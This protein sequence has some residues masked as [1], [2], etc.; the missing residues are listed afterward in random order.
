[1]RGFTL[2]EIL[3]VLFI[4]GITLSFATLSIGGDGG[5]ERLQREANR[6]QALM[7]IAK[8]DA[9]LFG[10]EIGLDLTRDGYRF[11]RLDVDGWRVIKRTDTPLRPRKLPED[12]TLRLL[13]R[14]DEDQAVRPLAPMGRQDDEGEG[15]DEN[16]DDQQRN[17]GPRPEVLFL[18]SG[19]T[20]PFEL[21]LFA[22]DVA[23]RYLFKG[24]RSGK[25]RMRRERPAGA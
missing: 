25:I 6:L 14:E 2:V 16:S 1:M 23:V 24:E 11:L 5:A 12:M 7:D 9:V 18:S 20:L 19:T 17:D 22:E 4:I 3:V 15:E 13:Q 10:A 21:V 8:E